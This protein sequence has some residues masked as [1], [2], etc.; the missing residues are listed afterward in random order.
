[1]RG[2]SWSEGAFDGPETGVA[3]FVYIGGVPWDHFAGG[4]EIFQLN[5]VCKIS[6]IYIILNTWCVTS[7][8]MVLKASYF[9]SFSAPVSIRL[10]SRSGECWFFFYLITG[11]PRSPKNRIILIIIFFFHTH[12]HTNTSSYIYNVPPIGLARIL[13]GILGALGRSGR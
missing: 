6:S 1:M 9:G 5:L 11:G 13:Q 7:R 2:F 12:T 3:H 10:V 8:L 4:M